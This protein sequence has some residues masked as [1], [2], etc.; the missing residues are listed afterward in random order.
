MKRLGFAI[1]AAHNNAATRVSFESHVDELNDLN[2][3]LEA[4]LQEIDDL[5]QLASGLE[6]VVTSFESIDRPTYQ[7]HLNARSQALS[8]LR[9]SGLSAS[10]S[11]QLVPSME[12][13]EASSGWQKFKAFLLKLWEMVKVAAKK[14]YAFI[15]NIL[16]SSTVAEKA[17]ILKLRVLRQKL[18]ARSGSMSVKATVPL[19][20]AH[21]YIVGSTFKGQDL[22]LMIPQSVEDVNATVA[23]WKKGRSIIQTKLPATLK[24]VSKDLKAAIDGLAL[25]GTD[26]EVS[27]SIINSRDVIHDAIDPMFGGYLKTHLGLGV[28][29]AFDMYPLVY[30]R[31]LKFHG[32][33]DA[34]EG[35]E[36]DNLS[37]ADREALLSEYGVSV[38][39]IDLEDIAKEGVSISAASTRDID[40]LLKS[41]Q[42]LLDEG[43]SSDQSR[44]W[45]SLKRNLDFYGAAVEGVLKAVLKRENLDQDARNLITFALHAR[46]ALLKWA[47]APYAQINT[48]NVRVVESLLALCSDFITNLDESEVEKRERDVA[49][50][51]TK[52]D[53]KDKSGKDK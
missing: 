10:E 50:K 39:Q 5:T 21:G 23:E 16:K 47:S 40:S 4:Q 12:A 48:L 8:L 52:K 53:D 32:V 26:E 46:R 3:S 25:T 20:S 7:H 41:A 49:E 34:S 6:G 9:M 30:D 13:G 33:S 14:V 27:T 43:Y 36:Y 17:A 24:Q 11:R 19:R 18:A 29:G 2:V 35:R 37:A 28:P 1:M 22:T 31:V 38:E 51:K 44:S 45:N 15:D 42:L